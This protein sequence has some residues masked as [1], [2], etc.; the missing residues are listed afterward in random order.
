MECRKRVEIQVPS[1]LVGRI[2][3]AISKG[4]STTEHGKAVVFTDDGKS[5][6]DASGEFQHFV[7]GDPVHNL[8]CNRGLGDVALATRKQWKQ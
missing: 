3:D 6:L 7:D 4:F 8:R 1:R 5:L 2:H